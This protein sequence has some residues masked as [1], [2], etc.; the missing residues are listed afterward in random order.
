ML[1]SGRPFRQTTRFP[2]S[3]ARSHDASS[4]PRLRHRLR[5]ELPSAATT[6]RARDARSH[7]RRPIPFLCGLSP[8][9]GAH[10]S[11][12]YLSCYSP[13]SDHLKSTPTFTFIK[14][15][16]MPKDCKQYCNQRKDVQAILFSQQKKHDWSSIFLLL[17]KLS[18]VNRMI[19][20]RGGTASFQTA[21][22]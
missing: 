1:S 21:G 5:C 15:V 9:R 10:S 13:T 16:I 19:W 18:L 12:L 3:A 20:T 6:V 2:V 14:V 22:T 17:L 8:G 7:R 11:K 4:C